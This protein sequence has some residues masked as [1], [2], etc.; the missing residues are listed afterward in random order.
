MLDEE[1]AIIWLLHRDLLLCRSRLTPEKYNLGKDA[2][3]SLFKV[4]QLTKKH[5]QS[6]YWQLRRLG[7]APNKRSSERRAARKA[8]SYTL[9]A[10]L[11]KGA[12]SL[13]I[14]NREYNQWVKIVRIAFNTECGL[15]SFFISAREDC[16]F[17]SGCRDSLDAIS[18]ATEGFA[19]NIFSK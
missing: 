13:G 7:N 14:G 12:L 3:I 15:L 4:F 18:R 10:V 17:E 9:Y 5:Q 6:P 8:L 2:S 11:P 16:L 19:V 1:L